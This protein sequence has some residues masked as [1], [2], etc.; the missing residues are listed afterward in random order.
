MIVQC[1]NCGTR[2]NLDEALIK[3]EGSRVR[4]SLCKHIFTVYP[5]RPEPE[6]EEKGAG[7]SVMPEDLEDTVALESSPF[8]Q[9]TPSSGQTSDYENLFEESI[10][11]ME[12]FEPVS[13]DSLRDVIGDQRRRREDVEPGVAA[14]PERVRPREAPRREE[15]E[16]RRRAPRPASVSKR[17]AGSRL[18]LVL[19]IVILVL[20]GGGAAIFLWAPEMI[21][22]SLS[23][24]KPVEEEEVAD[25]G[26]RRLSF[27][28]VRGS[29][30]DSK[31]AGNLFVIQGEIK[32][33]Y[34]GSRN[35]IL[36]RGSILDDQGRVVKRKLAFAGNPLA[37]D[38]LKQLTMEEIDK[39]MKNRYG[40]DRQNFNVSPGESVPFTIV[41]SSLPENLGEFTVEAVSSSPGGS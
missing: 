38:E 29:F 16:D 30:V 24:L 2:F 22:D 8:P 34:P 14:R 4:C 40:E 7:I 39:A 21:P 20:L 31:E 36:I 13:P 17:P 3:E 12:P 19:L 23:V 11:D 27:D 32:N 26:V 9:E 15:K 25:I 1:E 41:F 37:E 35:F 10:E 6:T 5:P 33:E 18:L 28:G